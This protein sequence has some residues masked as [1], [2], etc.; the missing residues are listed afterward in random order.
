MT[1][2]SRVRRPI[3]T[4][5][6]VLLIV[7]LGPSAIASTPQLE[8]S[9]RSTQT[10]MTVRL[11]QFAE[12]DPIGFEPF[13][14]KACARMPDRY[15]SCNCGPGW[16]VEIYGTVAQAPAYLWWGIST[17]H[18]A[19]ERG[20]GPYGVNPREITSTGPM[21]FNTGLNGPVY[22]GTGLGWQIER[23]STLGAICRTAFLPKLKVLQ[24][25]AAELISATIE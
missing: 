3:A 18:M 14:T 2:I 13:S 12:Q 22:Y 1:D 16:S 24:Q 4:L 25:P 23:W 20:G 5:M 8:V 15:A 9:T 11:T 10:D 19:G 21:S 7:A 6:A 17:N